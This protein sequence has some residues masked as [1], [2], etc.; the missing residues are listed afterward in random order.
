MTTQERDPR[1]G[2]QDAIAPLQL[3]VAC[4]DERSL[5][6]RKLLVSQKFFAP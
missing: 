2:E 4:A 6:C 5:L 3:E 1:A